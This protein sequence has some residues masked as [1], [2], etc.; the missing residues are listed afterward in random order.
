[1]PARAGWAAA[2]MYLLLTHIYVN[3]NNY[4]FVFERHL[5]NQ[6]SNGGNCSFS[7]VLKCVNNNLLVSN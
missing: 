6:S 5:E 1:M 3:N 7:G 4:R 2:A